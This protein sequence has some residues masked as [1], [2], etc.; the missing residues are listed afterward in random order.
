L[1]SDLHLHRQKEDHR[2]EKHLQNLDV[3]STRDHANHS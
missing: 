2:N 1:P 3:G